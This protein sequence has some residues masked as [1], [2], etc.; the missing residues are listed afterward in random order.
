M[1]KIKRVNGHHDERLWLFGHDSQHLF[2]GI[3][4]AT[5]Q[6]LVLK[7]LTV[8]H[9]AMFGWHLFARTNGFQYIILGGSTLDHLL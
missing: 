1:L 9:P 2:N 4:L 7:V 6:A 8:T 5:P 3:I